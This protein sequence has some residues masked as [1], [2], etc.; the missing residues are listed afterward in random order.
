[1]LFQFCNVN[2]IK[3]PLHDAILV[4]WFW[5]MEMCWNPN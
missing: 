5:N 3:G 4:S 1:M 2:S